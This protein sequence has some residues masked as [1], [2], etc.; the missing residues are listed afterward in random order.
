MALHRKLSPIPPA[1]NK[2]KI[3]DST[4]SSLANDEQPKT[5]KNVTNQLGSKD[6][7]MSN[8]SLNDNNF[9]SEYSTSNEN[10][11]NIDSN[12]NTVSSRLSELIS[13]NL[14]QIQKSISYLSNNDKEFSTRG[15]SEQ[16]PGVTVTINQLEVMDDD[17]DNDDTNANKKG[18]RKQH[19]MSDESFQQP[20]SKSVAGSAGNRRAIK[21]T[22]ASSIFRRVFFKDFINDLN[23][24]C[25]VLLLQKV[26][27]HILCQILH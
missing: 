9:N 4:S 19:S 14:P 8:E 17:Y 27:S 5:L 10:N 2:V 13:T 22:K 1:S 25:R 12:E 11:E 20:M 16:K 24:F 23:L 7:N 21:K 3:E 15:T 18:H 26:F 6:I